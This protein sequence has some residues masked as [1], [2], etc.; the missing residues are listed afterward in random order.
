MA[1]TEKQKQAT[2]AALVA[3]AAENAAASAAQAAHE[4]TRDAAAYAILAADI[5]A[6]AP[7][8]PWSAYQDLATD[9]LAKGTAST[10]TSK[11]TTAATAADSHK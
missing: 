8:K 2:Q 3:S 4:A 11:P 7:V 5:R 1:L 9:D 6:K 10:P